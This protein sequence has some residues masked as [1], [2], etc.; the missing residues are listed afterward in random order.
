MSTVENSV[1]QD[2]TARLATWATSLN[3]ASLS[4]E[5]IERLEI[6][7]LDHLGC[8]IAASGRQCGVTL[9]KWAE[10][11]TG[12]GSSPIIGHQWQVAAPVAAMVNAT[13]AHGMELDDTHDAS[14]SHPGASVIASALAIAAEKRVSGLAFLRAI[15]V[16]YE[17]T[18]RVGSATGASILERGFHPTALFG[19]FGAAA[20]A[21]SLENFDAQM[22]CDAWGL[23]LSMTGGSAQFSQD[24]RGTVVKRLH[25]GLG[26]N[27]GVTAVQ[28][29]SAGISGPAGAL[30]G[31]Y[32]ML[33]LYGASDTIPE[34]LMPPEKD[35]RL[36]I[37]KI[38][39]KPYP[40]CRLFHST[41]DALREVVGVLPIPREE[42]SRIVAIRVGGPSVLLSQHML[43]RPTSLMAAQY[44]LPYT[45]AAVLDQDPHTI[46]TFLEENLEDTGRL[47]LATRVHCDV[48]EQMNDAFPDHFGSSVEIEYEDGTRKSASRLDSLGTPAF[49]MSRGAVVAKLEGLFQQAGAG[50][51][52]M[53]LDDV[54]RGIGEQKDVS[55]LMA[56]L[57]RA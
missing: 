54:V 52:A 44:S 1:P 23:V 53:E 10:A 3:E 26:A 43:R 36:L 47:E 45:M 25:G 15:A 46:D 57:H 20:S 18:G 16:G 14:L 27:N 8:V 48:D 34:N 24:A 35:E 30:D 9:A 49:P 40:C 6:L 21:A 4:P 38:S 19:G 11:Y 5:D 7:L 31:K 41:I 42:Q 37:H 55:R 39:L 51:S 17:V 33:A 2:M 13:A 56:L 22:L 32:G 29:A 28:L 50:V 12:S